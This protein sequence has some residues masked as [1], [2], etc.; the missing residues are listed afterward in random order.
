MATFPILDLSQKELPVVRFTPE[1]EPDNA[2]FGLP[3]EGRLIGL[4]AIGNYRAVEWGG[5]LQVALIH[6]IDNGKTDFDTTF[7]Y[8]VDTTMIEHFTPSASTTMT[9][10][11]STYTR[12]SKP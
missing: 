5:R 2:G 3:V 11:G 12:K 9:V 10:D 7:A 8:V 4:Y 1:A 6:P